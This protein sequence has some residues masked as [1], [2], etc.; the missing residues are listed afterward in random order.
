M[1]VYKMK[2]YYQVRI[3][4]TMSNKPGAP[5]RTTYEAAAADLIKVKKELETWRTPCPEAA[6]I[7]EIK[8]K[9]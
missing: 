3:N 5:V 4:D 2:M 6:Y 1:E 8:S 9:N 7:E